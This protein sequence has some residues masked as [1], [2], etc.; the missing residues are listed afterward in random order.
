MFL[1]MFKVTKGVTKDC[2]YR[3]DELLRALTEFIN[4]YLVLPLRNQL[5]RHT[6]KKM[7]NEISVVVFN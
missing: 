5:F 7:Q 1:K 2:E 3:S 6:I 4:D